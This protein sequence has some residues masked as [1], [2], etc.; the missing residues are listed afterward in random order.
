MGAE[1]VKTDLGALFIQ[2]D[3]TQ[4]H[5]GRERR[6]SRNL[7]VNDGNVGRNAFFS[8][9]GRKVFPKRLMVYAHGAHE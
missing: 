7:F 6:G 2:A 4:I 3:N 9:E 8:H 1:L 5:R